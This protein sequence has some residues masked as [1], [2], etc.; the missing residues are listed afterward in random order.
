MLNN[1]NSSKVVIEKGPIG[2]TVEDI[3]VKQEPEFS[4]V[5]D[6]SF[7]NHIMNSDTNWDQ[8]FHVGE[9]QNAKVTSNLDFTE[10]SKRK[11][12]LRKLKNGNANRILQIS[13][14]LKQILAMIWKTWNHNSKKPR[15]NF[16]QSTYQK[17]TL[18]VLIKTTKH[19]LKK[20]TSTNQIFVMKN[21]F[22]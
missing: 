1:P 6:I 15:K 19:S 16:A 4:V 18:G 7:N 10:L 20:L 13:M 14:N 17:N 12:S 2:H 22:S 3:E 9:K 5:D 11:K 21:Y 8:T